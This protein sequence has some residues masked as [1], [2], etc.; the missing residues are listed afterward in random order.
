[1]YA[2]SLIK[3]FESTIGSSFQKDTGYSYVGE[4]KGSVQLANM[5]IDKQ[6]NPDVFVSAGTIP[7]MKS[8]IYCN[9][10]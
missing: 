7:I 3:R 4:S 5:S 6:R 9:F 8:R 1:M 2:G 10:I